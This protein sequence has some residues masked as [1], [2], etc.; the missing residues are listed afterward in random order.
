MPH[1]RPTPDCELFYRDDDFTD[2]WTKPETILMLHGNAESTNA[3]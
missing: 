2:P 3:A 1:F